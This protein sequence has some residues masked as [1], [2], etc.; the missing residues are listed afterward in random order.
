[1]AYTP[2]LT[3]S[4]LRAL[5]TVLCSLGS[6]THSVTCAR[7][8]SALVPRIDQSGSKWPATPTRKSSETRVQPDGLAGT[9]FGF[10]L[11]FRL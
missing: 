5:K 2:T 4:D 1:M 7:Q 3:V 11:G 8:W 9:W 6:H 10:G